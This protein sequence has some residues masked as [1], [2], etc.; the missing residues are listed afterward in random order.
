MKYK[1]TRGE[2]GAV[3]LVEATI[4]FPIVFF[5]MIIIMFIGNIYYTRAY[6]DK[7][8]STYATVAGRY[9][10]NE[11][12]YEI[13]KDGGSYTLTDH[14]LNPYA[15]IFG[16]DDEVG[17]YLEKQVKTAA[18]STAN[19]LFATMQPYSIKGAEGGSFVNIEN[20]FFG[21][22]VNVEINY[23]IRLLSGYSFFNFIPE[24]SYTARAEV[25]AIDSPELIRNID[26]IYDFYLD[27]SRT[28]T[29]QQFN[30]KI[31]TIFTKVKEMFNFFK[32]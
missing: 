3:T 13:N 14:D 2:S 21:A 11:T 28:E 12:L 6:M 24:L 9:L 10:A 17:N 30:E 15:Q 22:S 26:M 25:T 4:V 32:K 5:V 8:A 16:V 7:V 1:F 29:G 19:T 20:G 23:K 31:G 27:F 18:K